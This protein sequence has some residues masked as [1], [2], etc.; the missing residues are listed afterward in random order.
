MK[1]LFLSWKFK[2]T[3]NAYTLIIPWSFKVCKK[4]GFGFVANLGK[5]NPM[6]P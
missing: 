4:V 3:P 2:L 6:S 5:D 1:L